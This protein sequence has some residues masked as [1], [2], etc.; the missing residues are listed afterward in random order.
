MSKRTKN[1]H[2]PKPEP[3]KLG[4]SRR[5]YATAYANRPPTKRMNN[6]SWKMVHRYE[7]LLLAVIIELYKKKPL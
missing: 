1:N 3:I 5:T 6:W 4:T 2:P 7:L